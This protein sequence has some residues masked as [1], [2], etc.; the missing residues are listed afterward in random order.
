MQQKILKITEDYIT[1]GQLLKLESYIPSG[2][3]AKWYLSEFEVYLNNE[4]EQ[5][6][7]KKLYSGDKIFLPNEDMTITIQQISP[8]KSNET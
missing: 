2:G 1:L 8:A 7:G 6:R 4:L 5:R 3:M